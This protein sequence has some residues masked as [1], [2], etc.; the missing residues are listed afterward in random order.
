M[1]MEARVPSDKTRA[2]SSAEASV[3]EE[4]AEIPYEPLLPIEIKLIVWSLIVGAVL[5]V[6]LCWS[7]FTFF[8]V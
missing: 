4:L 6:I 1:A 7:C 5:L 8:A 2:S 3:A